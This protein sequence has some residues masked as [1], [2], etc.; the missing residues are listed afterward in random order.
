MLN[1][2]VTFSRQ[3]KARGGNKGVQW[4]VV[5]SIRLVIFQLNLIKLQTERTGPRRYGITENLIP[6]ECLLELGRFAIWTGG[7]AR[8]RNDSETRGGE[9]FFWKCT[10]KQSG[11]QV[12][13]QM[14]HYD[15][16]RCVGCTR[17]CKINEAQT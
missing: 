10:R 5:K 12:G 14:G 9:V 2:F 4:D 13:N 7:N 8:F 17:C 6:H 16:S 1:A 15:V 11:E 3:W